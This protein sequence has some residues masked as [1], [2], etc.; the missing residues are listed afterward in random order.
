MTNH[1]VR[2][3]NKYYENRNGE[4]EVPGMLIYLTKWYFKLT[5]RTGRHRWVDFAQVGG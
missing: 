1:D 5:V 2:F 3:G 4:E